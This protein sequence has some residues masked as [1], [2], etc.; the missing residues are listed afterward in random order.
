MSRR[1]L[2]FRHFARS[3]LCAAFA[4]LTKAEI[5]GRENIPPSGSLIVA[6]NHLAH[7]DPLLVIAAM[8][9]PVDPIALSDLYSVPGTGL[10]LRAYGA[11]PVHRDQVDRQVIRRALN[12]L[13][14][15]GVIIL[16]PEARRSVTGALE[17]ARTGAA[18]LALKSRAPVLPVAI[19]G[20]DKILS[21]LKRLRRPR[22]T[23][24][25]GQPFTLSHYEEDGRVQRVKRREA[26]DEIMTHIAQMLPQ[27]YRGVYGEFVS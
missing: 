14:G 11:V 12:I 26:T 8:P 10:A 3:F 5:H 13:R 4:T 20:T 25:F 9:Y 27:E 19:T 22:L 17:R 2:A 24:A 6:F 7:L 16:A 23:A 21:E 1:Q 18:Y 15:G